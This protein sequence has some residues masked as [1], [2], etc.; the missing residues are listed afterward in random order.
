[1][2]NRRR[3][4]TAQAGGAPRGSVASTVSTP[5]CRPGSGPAATS[6]VW[7]IAGRSRVVWL[8]QPVRPADSPSEE[9]SMAQ[10][11]ANKV[12]IVTGGGG[13]IGEATARLFWEEG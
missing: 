3:S 4:S 5:L 9:V 7:P 2:S 13:G 1:M 12:A 11:L 10:R 6:A 8:A